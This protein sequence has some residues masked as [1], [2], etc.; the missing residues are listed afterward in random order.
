LVEEDITEKRVLGGGK[1]TEWRPEKTV[2]ADMG[3]RAQKT[4]PGLWQKPQIWKN[5]REK[6]K[7][8][9]EKRE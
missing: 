9:W 5:Y 3:D 8:G 7:D 2:W 1:A 4:K 6:L